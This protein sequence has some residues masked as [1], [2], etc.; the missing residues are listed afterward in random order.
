M[1]AG[2]N[3]EAGGEFTRRGSA[4]HLPGGLQHQHR[5]AASGERCGAYQ[6]VVAGADH[7]AI[8][9]GFHLLNAHA[10]CILRRSR[11][12]ARAA[13]A[14]GAPMTPPPGCVL[15]PHMYM[16]RTGERYCA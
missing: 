9:T 12:T 15:D 8:V 2:R 11:S 1:R 4:P 14:P 13:L 16:P 3:A 10:G 7:D 5:T 6:S